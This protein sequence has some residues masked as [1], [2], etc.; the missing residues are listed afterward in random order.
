MK[1]VNDLVE[2]VRL[3]AYEVDG[4]RSRLSQQTKENEVT[5]GSLNDRLSQLHKE[6]TE[7]QVSSQWLSKEKRSA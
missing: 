4:L 5:I 3:E 2:N 6:L 7:S 1:K